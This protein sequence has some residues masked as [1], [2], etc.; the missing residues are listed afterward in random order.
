MR[1]SRSGSWVIT[2]CVLFTGSAAAWAKDLYVQAKNNPQSQGNGT[3]SRP[4]TSL[5]DVE[6]S[7]EPGDAIHVL[8]SNFALD[9]GIHLKD[10]QRLIGVGAQVTAVPEN[11]AHAQISNSTGG[12]LSGDAIRLADNN[13]VENIH[14]V[15][16]YRGGIL[17]VNVASAVI[18]NNLITENTSSSPPPAQCKRTPSISR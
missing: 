12:H 2:V 9:G 1:Y 17:G 11:A 16:A 10:G 5:A 14:V 4:F 8:P 15:G 6:A 13:T 18:E 7:S 3:H